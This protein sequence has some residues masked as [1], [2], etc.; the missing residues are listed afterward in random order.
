MDLNGNLVII[1]GNATSE[2]AG[3]FYGDG[4]A[5]VIE[6]DETYFSQP[7]LQ[8]PIQSA[9]PCE[10]QIVGSFLGEENRLF[11]VEIHKFGQIGL[12][13]ASTTAIFK[14][15]QA[16]LATVQQQSA[17]K[18]TVIAS[19]QTRLTAVETSVQKLQPHP[20]PG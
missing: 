17:Q 8:V 9:D 2:S 5:A 20:S 11:C 10:P 12:P 15:S 13:S 14:W 6:A 3:R 1:G 7:D 19:L 4:L 16:Q 18:E